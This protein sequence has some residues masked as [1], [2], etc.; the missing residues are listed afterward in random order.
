MLAWRKLVA[1]IVTRLVRYSGSALTMG[2]WATP[3]QAPREGSERACR[4]AAQCRHVA[5]WSP[6]RRQSA[7]RP[8]ACRC[9]FWRRPARRAPCGRPAR[10]RRWCPRGIP[11]GRPI[12]RSVSR[13]KLPAWAAPERESADGMQVK[14]SAAPCAS[15]PLWPAREEAPMV[16]APYFLPHQMRPAPYVGCS[17]VRRGS[18]PTLFFTTPNAPRTLR[19]MQ[20]GASRKWPHPIFYRTG[21]APHLAVLEISKRFKDF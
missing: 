6:G 9:R 4:A 19:R 1:L 16:P 8:M 21:C 20:Q 18:G 12:P 17:E 5:T 2:C 7:S 15:C 11:E 10:P 13:V 3:R 14:S